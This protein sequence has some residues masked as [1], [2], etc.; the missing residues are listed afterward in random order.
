[1]KK[2]FEEIGDEIAVDAASPQIKPS[3]ENYRRLIR[4]QFLEMDKHLKDDCSSL[5][6]FGEPLQ[7]FIKGIGDG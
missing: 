3:F 5:L 2:S 7:S 1:M 6:K 4:Y